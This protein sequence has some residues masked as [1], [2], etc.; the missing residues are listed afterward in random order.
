M[1]QESAMKRKA[2][3]RRHPEGA[4]PERSEEETAIE[5]SNVPATPGR[6][7]IESVDEHK[8]GSIESVPPAGPGNGV[9]GFI[10]PAGPDAEGRP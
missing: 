10:E 3:V 9:A 8:T 2:K 1:K 7:S 4:P 6:S 5:L